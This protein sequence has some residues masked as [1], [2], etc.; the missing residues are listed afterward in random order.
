MEASE[1]LIAMYERQSPKNSRRWLLAVLGGA[2]LLSV[3]LVTA[4]FWLG[5]R[6]FGLSPS[7]SGLEI[8]FIIAGFVG[9][10]SALLRY[11]FRVAL[12][13]AIL[14]IF[15]IGPLGGAVFGGL[16]ATGM[17]LGA[18]DDAFRD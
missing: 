8:P 7:A 5:L 2:T 16:A 14:S 13:G 15:S 9:A 10:A 17:I 11:N 3:Q 1:K 18:G 6:P 4:A 12:V